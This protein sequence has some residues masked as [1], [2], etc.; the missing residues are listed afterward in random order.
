[1]KSRPNQR[2]FNFKHTL[3]WGMLYFVGAKIFHTTS[4]GALAAG[5]FPEPSGTFRNPGEPGGTL[6]NPEIPGTTI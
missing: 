1:M 4:N 5:T 2:N 6:R 3:G